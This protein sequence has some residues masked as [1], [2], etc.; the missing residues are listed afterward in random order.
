MI[1]ILL[2]DD[3]TDSRDAIVQYI[4][5]EGHGLELVGAAGDGA[6]ALEMIKTRKPDIAILDIY[7]PKLSGIQVIERCRREM[8]D[9]PAFI[10]ISGCN[11]FGCAQQAIRLKVEEYLLKPF[12][13]RELMDA[14]QRA[15][16]QVELRA[17]RSSGRL[18][19]LRALLPAGVA[20]RGARALLHG[21]GAPGTQRRLRRQP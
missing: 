9:A 6:E 1:K 20:P 17:R 14:V 11:D 19:L 7:M 8:P 2:A 16:L 13:A 12:L 3:E 21:A 18:R 5:W 10:I 15:L 4:D